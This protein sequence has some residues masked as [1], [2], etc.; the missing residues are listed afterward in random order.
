MI[1]DVDS[2]REELELKRILCESQSTIHDTAGTSPNSACNHTTM[3]FTQLP[4]GKSYP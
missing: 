3:R 2:H 1:A 4:L